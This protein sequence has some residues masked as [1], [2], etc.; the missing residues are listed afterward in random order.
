MAQFTCTLLMAPCLPL[1]KVIKGLI[2]L[3]KL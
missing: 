3:G 2:Q 1:W